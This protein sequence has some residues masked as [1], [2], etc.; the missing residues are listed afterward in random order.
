MGAGFERLD[1]PKT[2][3]TVEEPFSKEP[4]LTVP[5]SNTPPKSRKIRS[6]KAPIKK[7]SVNRNKQTLVKE[8][9]NQ[10]NYDQ[11]N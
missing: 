7:G 3:L 5:N 8:P 6:L 1:E 11:K 4:S 9:P 2:Y 10:K